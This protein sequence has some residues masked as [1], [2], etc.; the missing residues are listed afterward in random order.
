MAAIVGGD[1]YQT[2]APHPREA[3]PPRPFATNKGCIS[4]KWFYPRLQS[5]SRVHCDRTLARRNLKGFIQSIMKCHIV[6]A[7]VLP[8]MSNSRPMRTI[9]AYRVLVIRTRLFH[10]AR[11][12][13]VQCTVRPGTFQ[14]VWL[15]VKTRRRVRNSER[16]TLPRA[17]SS[18]KLRA[19]SPP[20]RSVVAGLG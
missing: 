20:T 9:F 16:W 1:T 18:S 13:E 12:T 5:V 3:L 2:T 4:A 10:E 8:P 14:A 11:R 7:T 6:P 15:Q 17:R 19:M